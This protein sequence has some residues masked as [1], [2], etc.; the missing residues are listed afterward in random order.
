VYD[1]FDVLGSVVVYLLY[2]D[3]TFFVCLFYTVYQLRRSDTVWYIVYYEGF[4]VLSLR[5]FGSDT[6]L[7][8][9]L[10]VVVSADVYHTACGKVGKELEGFTFQVLYRG[11]DKFIEVDLLF[12][13][14]PKMKKL[15]K[16]YRNKNYVTDVLSFPFESNLEFSFLDTIPLGQI[17]ISP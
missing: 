9:L 14:A 8:A 13:V 2:V 17:I 6:Y 1:Y 7:A 15:N 10:P 4:V 12:V 5:Y 16:L 11:I 3:F